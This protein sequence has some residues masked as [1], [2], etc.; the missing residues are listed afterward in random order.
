MS[1]PKLTFAS[2][3][4]DRMQPLYTGEVKPEGF[5]LDFRVFEW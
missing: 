1:K 3:L 2:G 5:E 4:Y